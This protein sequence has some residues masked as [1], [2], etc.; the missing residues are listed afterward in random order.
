VLYCDLEEY[1]RAFLCS[2][3]ALKIAEELGDRRSVALALVNLGDLYRRQGRFPAALACLGTALSILADLQS[4]HDV[5][6]TLV[7]LA[8]TFLAQ[9]WYAEAEAVLRRAVALCRTLAI[10]SV[11]CAALHLSAELSFRDRRLEEA[12]ETNEESLRLA[13][14]IGRRDIQLRAHVFRIR[15]DVARGEIDVPAAVTSLEQMLAFWPRER[16]QEILY[17]QIWR[18]DPSR[19]PHGEVAAALC[20][21]LFEKSGALE[22]RRRY[23]DLTGQR[24]PDRDPLP[25]PPPVASS[26]RV[27]LD[28][29]IRRVDQI[30]RIV[31][32]QE[33]NGALVS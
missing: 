14:E 5:A 27:D 3:Q 15:L 18:L 23:E 22:D 24:L 28:D 25:E 6:E 26:T 10:P 1:S 31:R 30:I 19:Q 8:W 2:E 17:Y 16:E 9:E 29:P 4:P 11:L 32:A 12:A 33:Q 7:S 20:R 13:A 21:A